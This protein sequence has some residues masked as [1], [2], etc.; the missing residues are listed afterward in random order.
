[1]LVFRWDD[2]KMTERCRRHTFCL[3]A[4]SPRLP[5]GGSRQKFDLK[6]SLVWCAIFST[7]FCSYTHARHFT[8]TNITMMMTI[9][10]SSSAAAAARWGKVGM[11]LKCLSFLRWFNRCCF[12][13]QGWYEWINFKRDSCRLS[14][15][16]VPSSWVYISMNWK[17][18]FFM[19]ISV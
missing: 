15:F 7:L 1:M 17:M 5:D 6:V 9:L 13:N 4:G 18:Q 14:N 11:F 8:F 3:L 16:F 2:V 19:L 10:M 12:R